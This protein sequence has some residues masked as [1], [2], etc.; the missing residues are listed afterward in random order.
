MSNPR[1]QYGRMAVQ[2]TG[3]AGLTIAEAIRSGFV[4]ELM[5]GE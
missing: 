3:F 4:F 5:N 2:A 1:E